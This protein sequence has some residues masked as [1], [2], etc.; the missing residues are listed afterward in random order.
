MTGPTITVRDL[1]IDRPDGR[2]GRRRILGVAGL[3]LAPGTGLAVRGPSGSG[4]TT[5][6]LALAGIVTGGRGAVAWDGIDLAGMPP[7]ARDRLRRQ[8]LGLVFQDIHLIGGLSALQNVLLP[9]GFGALAVPRALRRR[10][11]DLLHRFGIDPGGRRADTLSRGEQGRVALARALI[12]DPPVIFADEPTAALDPDSGA[13][14][15]G[16]LGDLVAQGRTVL[17]VTH[18]P[19]LAARFGATLTLAAGAVAADPT[20]GGA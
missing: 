4:K 7:R 10:G 8:H 9:V 2:G 13:L 5:L 20:R 19:A 14:V 16:V 12:L 17:A 3:H 6:V 11:T 15:A 1:A 18:D